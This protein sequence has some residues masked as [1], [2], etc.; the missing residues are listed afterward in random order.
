MTSW[1]PDK[2]PPGTR[3]T[4]RPLSIAPMM[5]RTDRHYRRF[6]RE[7]TRKTLLYTEMV[8]Q[9][10][11][12]FG[13][14]AKLLGFSPEEHPISVQLGGDDPGSLAK[15]AA[16]VAE[17][18]YD[19]INL[20]VGCPSERVQNGNFGACLMAKPE[21]VA[22]CVRAMR[23]AADLPVTV[24][25]RIGI[26]DLDSF[27]HLSHF[28]ESVAEAGCD[29][30]TVHARKAWLSGLSPKQ[31]RTV[32]PLRYEEVYR[33]KR[34]F[35][36]LHIEINGGVLDLDSVC[37]HLTNVD[38]VMIGRAAY[39]DPSV[40]LHADSRIFGATG[41]S[42][43]LYSAIR[44]YLPYVRE[45]VAKG[46]PVGA[47]SRHILHLFRGRPGARQ[48]RRILTEDASRN[49]RDADI[50]EKAL[51]VVLVHQERSD[52]LRTPE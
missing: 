7:L 20:N 36:H 13:D 33:L 49:P 27:D 29:R 19:E 11:V 4:L 32:P 37:S 35:P 41:E 2:A 38:A 1:R 48:W 42:P 23:D 44:G 10:A 52:H 45:Q 39:D 6:M 51:D 18:G 16:I 25:H 26:D 46:V 28:V 9:N 24:K 17:L 47:L 40:F 3:G 31:N 21:V 43:T 50:V 15:C 5:D 8:T 34:M 22:A 14:R 12:L 30:F